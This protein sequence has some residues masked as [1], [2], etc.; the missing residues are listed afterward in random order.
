[1]SKKSKKFFPSSPASE[2]ICHTLPKFHTHKIPK[3]LKRGLRTSNFWNE[4][5][6]SLR[7]AKRN[8]IGKTC[9]TIQSWISAVELIYCAPERYWRSFHG[10]D[11]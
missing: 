3:W 7:Y 10:W 1:M 8:L 9:L 6:N 11:A 5:V 4:L 2:S